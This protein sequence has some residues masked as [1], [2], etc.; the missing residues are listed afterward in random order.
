MLDF[1]FEVQIKINFILTKSI[2]K[3][4]NV[5]WGQITMTY[6]VLTLEIFKNVSDFF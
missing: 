5:I 4:E 2:E 6:F 3:W 1:F